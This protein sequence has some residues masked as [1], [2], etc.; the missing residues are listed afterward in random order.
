MDQMIEYE[1]FHYLGRCCIERLRCDLMGK[2]I[3]E[4]ENGYCEG[5]KV[6]RGFESAVEEGRAWE[7]RCATQIKVCRHDMVPG[8]I[9]GAS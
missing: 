6:W 8:Q 1:G 7:L 9:G 4:V 2:V 3:P 5:V